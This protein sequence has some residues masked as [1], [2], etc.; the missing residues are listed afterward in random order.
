MLDVMGRLVARYTGNTT[1]ECAG[2]NDNGS[3]VRSGKWVY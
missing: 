2:R 1:T 3:T